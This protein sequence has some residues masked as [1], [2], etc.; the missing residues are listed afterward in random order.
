MGISMIDADDPAS[1]RAAFARYPLWVTPQRDDELWAAGEFVY[2]SPGYDGLGFWTSQNRSI[3]DQDIVAW[4]TLGFHH[5]ARQEDAPVLPSLTAS[6]SL[7]PEN[8]FEFNPALHL[9]IH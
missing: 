3:L 9:P 8:F 4:F 5:I 2:Q 1:A 7:L 6:F